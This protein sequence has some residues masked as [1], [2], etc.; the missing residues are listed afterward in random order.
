MTADRFNKGKPELHYCDTFPEGQRGVA[1]VSTY[2]ASKYSAYNY[3]K[4]AASSME[5]YSAARRH[6]L[7]WLNGE[8]MVP[9]APA[10]FGVKHIDAIIWNW[11]RLSQELVDYPE[12]DTRPCK[13]LEEKPKQ[14]ELPFA[15]SHPLDRIPQGF[16]CQEGIHVDAKCTPTK[17]NL[18]F[19]QEQA[20]QKKAPKRTRKAAQSSA[21][22]KPRRK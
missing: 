2:G 13:V 4:G 9:D 11:M 14:L 8:D 18:M 5:S 19:N 20:P 17:C 12:R 7:A 21:A 3:L 15:E 16:C 6:E 1:R 10:E 22:R